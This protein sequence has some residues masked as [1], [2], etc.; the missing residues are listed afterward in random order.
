MP[1]Q[2]Q[3][4]ADFRPQIQ[5]ANTH[6]PRGMGMLAESMSN[7]GW[8]GAVTAAAD[9][10]IFDGSARIE[11]AFTKFGEI[12]PIVIETDGHT[13]IIV[14]RMD[15]PSANHP[16]AKELAIAA[17]RVAELNLN[18][19]VEVIL[20]LREEI[21]LSG[22]FYDNEID[23]LVGTEE[24]ESEGESEDAPLS[25]GGG[26]FGDKHALAIILEEDEYEQWQKVKESIGLKK[27]TK[28]FLELIKYY[29]EKEL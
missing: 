25:F 17:N 27:D 6:T 26:D 13:P 29:L 23:L 12:E 4:L 10:E 5:N 11:T 24:G 14:K 2:K 22:Y 9:G 16:K 20:E 1:K 3:S 18:W 8:S 7:N 15:I 21:D 28:A 19:D